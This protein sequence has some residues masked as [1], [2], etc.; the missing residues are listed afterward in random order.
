MDISHDHTDFGIQIPF[1]TFMTPK[2]IYFL[3]LY[4]SIDGLHDLFHF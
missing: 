3:E 2:S 1:M 4:R